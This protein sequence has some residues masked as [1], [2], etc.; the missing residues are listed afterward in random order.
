MQRQRLIAIISTFGLALLMTFP[1]FLPG[2]VLLPLD[3]PRDQGIW[4]PDPNSRYDISNKIV[5]DPIYEYLAWDREI[6]RLL[7]SGEM[8]WRNQ[9][10]ADGAHL[11]ANPETALLFPFTWPRL[12]FGDRGWAVMALLKLWAGSL[13]MWWLSGRFAPESRLFF[14]FVAAAVY[15]TSGYMTVWLLFPHTNVFAVL[16]WLTGCAIHLIREPSRKWVTATVIAA[17]LA[18]AG[19]HPETLFHGVIALAAFLAIAFWRERRRLIVIALAAACGFLIVAVQI[20]P[21][22]LALSKSDIVRTRDAATSHHAR[23]FTAVAQLLPGFLGSPL[24]GEI[25]L[26]GIAQPAAENFN[27][28]SNG[29][30]GAITLLA[31]MTAWR[32]LSRELRLGLLIGL[33]A[34]VIS[35]RLPV[36][37]D[38]LRWLPLFS[39]AANERFGLVF[40]LFAC[41]AI[42]AA[43]TIIAASEARLRSGLAVAVVAGLVMLAAMTPV[44]PAGR[45]VL[46]SA[47]QKG[48][49]AMQQRQFLRKPR[50]YYDERLQLYLDGAKKVAVR[51]VAVPAALVTIAGVALA[52]RRKRVAAAAILGA[53][54]VAETLAFAWGYAPAVRI[55]DGPATPPAILS[56]QQL[57]PGRSFLIAAATGVYDANLGTIDRV[58]DVRSYDVLQESER[59]ERLV[60]LGFDRNSRAFPEHLSADQVSGL[61]REGVRFFLSRKAP[62]GSRLVGGLPEPGAGAYELPG[63][64]P[65]PRPANTPP[66]GL[67]AGTIVSLL[68]L[69][70][71]MALVRFLPYHKF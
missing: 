3:H 1:G 36:I 2:R 56:V 42:P 6:R 14:R 29:Y 27:E 54:A 53:A 24:R 48:I 49:T 35:W 31:L 37:D 5:S 23:I 32:R 65:V 26:S 21:F 30:A 58:R 18:T 11:Y 44:V 63:S 28:R 71:S 68:A 12:L 61:A 69:A 34:L 4:K 60:R 62:P 70:A 19:G 33:A 8:P 16:P 10:A 46:L 52:M 17:A 55:D 22:L 41:A 45:S 25:D 7:Q 9:W 50:A 59:I 66:S 15:A 51:R 47:A 43:L 39:V 38:A 20:V 57:D 13:G 40:I 64:Q 67:K